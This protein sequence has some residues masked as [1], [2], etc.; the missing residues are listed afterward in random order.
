MRTHKNNISQVYDLLSLLPA[1]HKGRNP[2]SAATAATAVV[3]GGSTGLSAGRLA[4]AIVVP[5]LAS[6]LLLLFFLLYVRWLNYY[7]LLGHVSHAGQGRG[8]AGGRWRG[9]VLS[10]SAPRSLPR[11]N[12]GEN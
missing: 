1:E 12:S 4:A 11:Q 7:D 8:G 5:V 2:T 6:L 3:I 10:M 9:L